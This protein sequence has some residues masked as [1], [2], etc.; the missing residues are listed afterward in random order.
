M[1][2]KFPYGK[3]PFW[4]LVLAIAS[5]LSLFFTRR[6]PDREKPDLILATF[7]SQ[8]LGAYR[9]AVPAFE[10]QH[11]VRMVAV[12]LERREHRGIAGRPRLARLEERR[13]P[14]PHDLRERHRRRDGEPAPR[15]ARVVPH[16]AGPRDLDRLAIGEEPCDD[17]ADRAEHR[18]GV[19]DDG[20]R[21]LVDRRRAVTSSWVSTTCST[22]PE[23][24]RTGY[25]SVTVS[26]TSWKA[27]RS[28]VQMTTS[29][30]CSVAWVVRVAMTSSAS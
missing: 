21:H 27:S 23:T 22:S 16:V 4:L 25:S 18:R 29:M 2:E 14:G 1:V 8:H 19:R 28:P 12:R 7:T 20:L 24:P 3:A 11:G 5:S 6:E 30:P 9:K 13:L 15:V 10:R 17:D 26:V